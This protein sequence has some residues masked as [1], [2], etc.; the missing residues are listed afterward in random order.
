MDGL[1]EYARVRGSATSGSP[2]GNTWILEAH[3]LSAD[4]TAWAAMCAF[5]GTTMRY[6][7]RFYFR[8]TQGPV[9]MTSASNSVCMLN[10]ISGKFR[11]FGESVHIVRRNDGFWWL[12]G[13]SQQGE[14]RA[15]AECIRVGP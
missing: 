4:Y 6:G 8:T 15:E 1:G 13:F 3:T 14:L 5:T 2:T 12:E 7:G 11:G 10:S 9:R